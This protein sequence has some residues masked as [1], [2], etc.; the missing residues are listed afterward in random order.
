MNIVI[1]VNEVTLI[2]FLVVQWFVSQIGDTHGKERPNKA[3]CAER[4]LGA[5]Y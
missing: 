4:R 3:N 5:F 1:T 2:H